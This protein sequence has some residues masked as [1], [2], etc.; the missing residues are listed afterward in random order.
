MWS[1]EEDIP[2]TGYKY[3]VGAEVDQKNVLNNPGRT[4]R[5][6]RQFQRIPRAH[7]V[8]V[9]MGIRQA[10]KNLGWKGAMDE[11]MF[12]QMQNRTWDM[13]YLPKGKKPLPS[14]WVYAKKESLEGAVKKARL[15]VGG[16]R[17]KKGIDFSETFASV[18][19]YQS[20]RLLLAMA[21]YYDWHVH[22][23]DFVTAF[24]NARNLHET[25]TWL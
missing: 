6:K 12:S 13:V 11:E 24:L 3:D 21:T 7:A 23:M 15:V 25:T 22:Q 16:H 17:Q 5:Q 8:T 18:V 1:D 20:I 14:R 2:R 19:K 4:R 10:L 9:E